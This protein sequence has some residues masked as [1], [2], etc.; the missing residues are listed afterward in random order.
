MSIGPVLHGMLNALQPGGTVDMATAL[1]SGVREMASTQSSSPGLSDLTEAA[2]LAPNVLTDVGMSAMFH[3]TSF[4]KQ[5]GQT[6]D[7]TNGLHWGT[8]TEETRRPVQEAMRPLEH[9]AESADTSKDM[10]AKASEAAG[11]IWLLMGNWKAAEAPLRRAIALD[12]RRVDAW[13][14]L[15]GIMLRGGQYAELTSLL[16]T[17]V[18]VL[19][20]ARSHLL[21]AKAYS[22]ANQPEK[23][24]LQVQAALRVNPEDFAANM[25]QVALLLQRSDNPAMLAEAGKQLAKLN[26]LYRKTPTLDNWSSFTLLLSIYSALTGS[27]LQAR[28]HLNEILQR[29]EANDMAKQALA[30]L[31]PETLK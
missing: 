12:P 24:A 30:A 15:T 18:K 25:A 6:H 3:T 11:V 31:G 7:M 23:A 1:Q 20:T 16:E 21:L 13:D 4:M 9:L 17:R 22:K 26:D 10:A 28:Q 14:A 2:R 27:E 29:D 8:L 19:D 5:F